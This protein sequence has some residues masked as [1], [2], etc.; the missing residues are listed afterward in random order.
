MSVAIPGGQAA[1]G[2]AK[3]DNAH[4][5]THLALQSAIVIAGLALALVGVPGL[6]V[7]RFWALQP[8]VLFAPE[9]SRL[10]QGLG[11]A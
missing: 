4:L 3:H 11:F 7:G 5:H 6:A 10:M 2:T 8:V 1:A 9:L